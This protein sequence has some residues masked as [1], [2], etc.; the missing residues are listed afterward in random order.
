MA[1]FLC[2]FSL[3]RIFLMDVL[4]IPIEQLFAVYLACSLALAAVCLLVGDGLLRV[5]KKT[6]PRMKAWLVKTE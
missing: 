4:K 3:N 6:A 1:L 2:H 5:W